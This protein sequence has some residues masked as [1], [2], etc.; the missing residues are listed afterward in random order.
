MRSSPSSTFTI[1]K[2]SHAEQ[3]KYSNTSRVPNIISR[4]SS[5]GCGPAARHSRHSLVTA[6][7]Q[8]SAG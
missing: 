6:I 4:I 2:V 1:C 3:L 7:I 8:I 5:R